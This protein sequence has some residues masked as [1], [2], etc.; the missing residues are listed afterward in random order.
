MTV[1]CQRVI[2]VVE[3]LAPKRW[4]EEW[5][6]VGLMTGSPS[7]PVGKVFV[8]LDVTNELVRRLPPD[9]DMIISHH[10]LIFKPLRQLREDL[11]EGQLLASLLRRGIAVYC[12]HTNFDVAPGGINDW[13][14]ERLQLQKTQP[15]QPGNLDAL[16]KVTVFVPQ[17]QAEVVH[18]AM[19]QAGAG[20]LGN[21]SYCSFQTPGVGTFLP[22]EGARPFVG[23]TG[24][25]ERVAEIRLETVVPAPIL[26]R[27]I[28]A[29][30][31]AHPYEEVAYDVVLMQN[32]TGF[33]GLGRI[34]TLPDVTVLES[35]A[36]QVQER[37]GT[38]GVRVV[39]DPKKA[40]HK[41]AVCGGSGVSM[42]SKAAH[43]GADVLV[44]GD[45]KYHEAQQAL[46]R[47]V[48]LI[49][50]G[51]FATEFAAVTIIGNQLEQVAGEEGWD[52]EVLCDTSAKDVFWFL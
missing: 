46:E 48:A 30:R 40:V 29:M 9:I 32:T 25:L 52:I 10:P 1:S 3:R 45:V 14:A 35:F 17:E 2:D 42:L 38:T 16:Y 12:A 49:D 36:V 39:G 13:L 26:D 4:A 19:A 37:L 6:N 23:V 47:G 7:Q 43:A 31:K 20:R 50:A 24:K 21:Y 15:L 8:T 51:H 18:Q 28:R 22:L 34:G 33:I 41:V 11:P 44:T 27:V 5:D